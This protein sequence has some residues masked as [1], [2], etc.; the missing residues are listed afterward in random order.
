MLRDAVRWG[1]IARNPADMSDPPT[2]STRTP[3]VKAW[4]AAT[5]RTF[6]EATRGD[7]LWP[8]WLVM[9]TTGLRRG[10]ALGLRW[11]D[12]DFDTGR[13]RVT[14][15]VTAIGWQIHHGQPK[16]AAGRRPVALDPATVVVLADLRAGGRDRDG[17]VFCGDDGEALHPERVYQACRRAVT[18]H[19][20][21]PIALHGLRHTWA[22][23]ALEQGVHPRVVQER[24]G[25]S[26]IA[27]TL[28]I[29][30]HVMPTMHDDAA[31]TVAALITPQP[32]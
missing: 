24:L 21:P 12:I 31:V 20:L 32:R 2:T 10:E 6:L 9:A 5:L 19:R 16:T 11:C 27:I 4:T 18:R 22:T 14:Q 30:S 26:N 23:I 29:Y 7:E 8:L 15:T 3:Q 13:A 17:L 25:H 28:Q 1:R